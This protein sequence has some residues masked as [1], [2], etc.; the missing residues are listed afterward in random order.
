MTDAEVPDEVPVVE[1]IDITMLFEGGE[2]YAMVEMMAERTGQTDAVGEAWVRVIWQKLRDIGIES[3]RDYVSSVLSVNERLVAYGHGPL[4]KK[5][6]TAM[7]VEACEMMFGPL[8]SV[9]GVGEQ[10]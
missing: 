6:L 2:S 8:D 7:L 1:A 9:E 3:V 4:Y 10:E 5:T